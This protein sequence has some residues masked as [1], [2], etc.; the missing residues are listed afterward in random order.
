ML[1]IEVC[2]RILAIQYKG[3]NHSHSNFPNM[4]KCLVMISGGDCGATLAYCVCVLYSG[5]WELGTPK[6]L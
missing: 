6:G 4:T 5:T 3:V 1:A 2:R